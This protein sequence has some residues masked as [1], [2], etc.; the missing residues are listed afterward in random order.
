MLARFD[1]NE[2]FPRMPFEPIDRKTYLRLQEE[3]L[4]RRTADDFLEAIRT[5]D[6]G[7]R[8]EAGPAGCD[9]DTCLLPL[10]KP[11]EVAA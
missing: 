8:M 10:A 3:V 6:N 7:P 9:S 5:Y 1:A 4:S 11:A 2:T